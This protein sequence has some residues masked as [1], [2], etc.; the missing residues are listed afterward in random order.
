MF[1]ARLCGRRT[2]ILGARDP[3]FV[4]RVFAF[5]VRV[6][7]DSMSNRFTATL[8]A[9]G[10]M[11]AAPGVAQ[12]S[13]TLQR[14]GA[15]V[16]AAS[17]PCGGILDVLGTA[18]GQSVTLTI[19]APVSPGLPAGTVVPVLLAAGTVTCDSMMAGVPGLRLAPATVLPLAT[20]S[21][22]AGGSPFAVTFVMPALPNGW[23]VGVQA[24]AF[25]P[26][27]SGGAAF[28]AAYR[29]VYGFASGSAP[30]LGGSSLSVQLTG[31][32]TAQFL[33]AGLATGPLTAHP[34]GGDGLTIDGAGF[35]ASST[36]VCFTGSDGAGGTVV[37]TYSNLDADP[38]N[39]FTVSPLANGG[40]KIV[41]SQ[42]PAFCDGPVTAEAVTGG[43]GGGPGTCPTG[44]LS[45]GPLVYQHASL[46]PAVTLVNFDATPVALARFLGPITYFPLL[47]GQD[48]VVDGA[49]MIAGSAS[50]LAGFPGHF[51]T[52][53]LLTDPTGANC[54]L[55]DAG[56]QGGVSVASPTR[57]LA[58]VP[59]PVQ[60]AA[61]EVRPG[62]GAFDLTL[63]NS[64][65]VAAPSP[66]DTSATLAVIVQRTTAPSVACFYPNVAVSN[67]SFLF[68]IFGSGFFRRAGN[69][70]SGGLGTI[71][72]SFPPTI[73]QLDLRDVIVPTVV[74]DALTPGG[75][76]GVLSPRVRFVSATELVAATPSGLPVGP[77]AITVFNP[78]A[79]SAVDA[80]QFSIVPALTDA[81]NAI[82]TETFAGAGG[83]VEFFPPTMA[84]RTLNGS[85]LKNVLDVLRNEVPD[86]ASFTSRV[87][88]DPKWA[89][90]PMVV[91]EN[92]ARAPDEG[93]REGT[94]AASGDVDRRS[95]AFLFNTR[96][97]DG[98]LRTFDFD[99]VDLPADIDFTTVAPGEAS[100]GA[101]APVLGASLS[102]TGPSLPGS[103]GFPT[104]RVT[105]KAAAFQVVTETDSLGTVSLGL[106]FFHEENY[107]LVVRSRTDFSTAALVELSGDSLLSKSTLPGSV[108]TDF[109]IRHEYNR[110]P[111]GAGP[112]G[113]GGSFYRI[114]GSNSFAFGLLKPH[115]S[116]A[117]D[118]SGFS[119]E[120]TLGVPDAPAALPSV[121]LSPQSQLID[122]QDGRAPAFR[123]L[124][125]SAFAGLSVPTI[126]G[127]PTDEPVTGGKGGGGVT[128]SG[129]QGGGGGGGGHAGTGKNGQT[130]AGGS[131]PTGGQ[132]HGSKSTLAGLASPSIA[133]AA[134]PTFFDS[135]I[136]GGGLMQ[137]YGS[138]G[139]AF[140]FRGA[141]R[142]DV[143][144][145]NYSPGLT[146]GTG[147]DVVGPVT[148]VASAPSGIIGGGTTPPTFPVGLFAG[149][150]GGAGGG[151]SIATFAPWLSIG[152]RGGNGGGSVVFVSDRVF[153]L[154]QGGR[155]LAD[156]EDGRLGLSVFPVFGEPTFVLS[157][158]GSGGGGAGGTVAIFATADFVAEPLLTLG[159][160]SAALAAANGRPAI[161]AR[162]GR[163]GGTFAPISG[164]P[165]SDGGDGCHGRVRLA[166]NELSRRP[167]CSTGGLPG[168]WS[169]DFLSLT[170]ALPVTGNGQFARITIAETGLSAFPSAFIT[171]HPADFLSPTLP[172]LDALAPS[173]GC[174]ANAAATIAV[175]RS[176]P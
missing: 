96:A 101:T 131:T 68:S 44:G 119:P 121:S 111:A 24:A 84:L 33:A 28:S 140:G 75:P 104:R 95:I 26:G 130:G 128:V 154:K 6:E 87:A 144:S 103:A 151:A 175:F 45:T 43:S 48:L 129:G 115:E 73:D 17:G 57:I 54:P 173:V 76:Q 4:A 161:S 108:G 170:T 137:N 163:G 34:E 138:L 139:G 18:G 174:A 51:Q 25:L 15:P 141:S 159:S 77:Y 42:S 100:F 82:T 59:E 153:T 172:P 146:T 118:P 132:F 110:A 148:T 135:E 29:L 171:P 2:V 27:T 41:I 164:I 52:R 134:R 3:R 127:A 63:V 158:P 88:A 162:A 78:D 120:K 5:A 55:L 155:I 39:N 94:S 150:S 176:T 36:Q 35:D 122:G 105:I 114:A 93:V 14:D 106:R 98:S 149:G 11:L 71:E 169:D 117:L 64:P 116:S 123:Q 125:T 167:S 49:F 107:P 152:G 124:R 102:L 69:N 142:F 136:V 83:T 60:S 13:L 19:A 89:F 9:L 16:V 99:A 7:K 165:T 166:H 90:P 74:F 23:N 58:T 65:C 40:T 79:Q 50:S 32:H 143:A 61:V 86:V 56:N 112:G 46:M 168:C 8:V 67:A 62:L 160:A 156:G 70:C 37:K 20:G 145:S 85:A 10:C 31:S 126:A 109:K 66:A 97:S 91:M 133:E 81:T 30:A 92:A 21:A 22:V 147:P 113:R 47:E 80:T 1:V 72:Q 38:T 12:V 53:I 157:A